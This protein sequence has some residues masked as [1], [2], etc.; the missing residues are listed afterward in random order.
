MQKDKNLNKKLRDEI[1]ARE[2][3]G[4][5]E[6]MRRDENNNKKKVFYHNI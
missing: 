3:E 4:E 1:V 2:R 6:K 5:R